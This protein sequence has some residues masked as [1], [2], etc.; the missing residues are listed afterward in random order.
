[1]NSLLLITLVLLWG[2]GGCSS[3]N[4]PVG[5]GSIKGVVRDSTARPLENVPITLVQTTTKESVSD[6][7]PITNEK[8]EFLYPDLPEGV[9]TLQC[10]TVEGK[11]KQV[12][13]QVFA[14]KIT[15]TQ[16]DLP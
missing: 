2:L 3:S 9:Y 11:S 8:G 1:M 4:P 15:H 13:V 6:R 5:H 7:A 10:S 12:E 14:N 16:I